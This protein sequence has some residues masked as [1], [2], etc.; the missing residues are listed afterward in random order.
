[1][2]EVYLVRHLHLQELRVVKILR[3]ELVTDP[4]AQK[5]FLREARLATQIKHPNV[6]ILYDYAR[7]PEGSFYM[8]W[9]HI[10]GEDVGQW[11]KTRGPFPLKL[12]LE[13]GIQALRG[14][15]AIHSAGV[16]HR[17]IS[18]DN[19]MI[20]RDHRSQFR[21]KII[22]L[23][24]AKNLIHDPNFE[25]TQTGMFMGKLQYCSPEQAEMVKGEVLDRRSDLYSF[26]LVLYEMICGLPPFESETQHGFIFKRLS[27]DP[28]PLAGRNP[29]IQVP[30]ALDRVLGQGL[31]RPREKRYP[32]AVSYIQALE[33]VAISLQE[34]E[35]QE[36]PVGGAPP[37][38]SGAEAGGR[39]RSSSQL[40]REERLELLAQIERAARRQRDTSRLIEEAQRALKE[41]RFEEAR[42]IAEQV[43]AAN[44]RAEGLADLKVRLQEV[45]Q[46]LAFRRRVA[47]AEKILERH[48]RQR[49]LQLARLALETLLDLYPHHPKRED[50]ENWVRLLAEEVEQQRRADEAMAAGREALARGDFKEAWRHL[51]AVAA[52]DLSGELEGRLRAE[53]EEAE[54]S[55]RTAA[56][57]A[58]HRRR[59]EGF[60][61]NG[62]LQEAEGEFKVLA[63]LGVPKVTLD[64]YRSRLE[65]VRLRLAEETEGREFE[66]R[67]RE[68]L[69]ARDWEG[70]REVALEYEKAFPTSRRPAELFAQVGRREE[71]HRRRE[72]IQRGEEEVARY[73]AAG[74]ADKAALALRILVQ[75]DPD[76]PHRRELQQQIEALKKGESVKRR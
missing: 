19:L 15:E 2:G 51:E 53:L 22:D 30:E 40:S 13:L 57:L 69:M 28:L 73:I 76:N 60:L 41:E 37:G 63:G 26:S 23:G 50:Y 3:Q 6:A 18:P 34:V 33:R 45:E 12:A 25:I 32:D 71:L 74:D 62:Q 72:S 39:T 35:T 16:I 61:E 58:E 7:L 66:R 56:D 65:E 27:E 9:E 10:E 44:P 55:E 36:L 31:E 70:A 43:E 59:L 29:A 48:V 67:F 49:H 11:I 1:M 75:M 38:L 68:R 47:E 46:T 4:E 20:T 8:V 24:L 21:L 14:L 54:R 42:K 64:F 5:R 52:N 17:D